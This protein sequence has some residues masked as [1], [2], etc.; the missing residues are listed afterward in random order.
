MAIRGILFDIGDT[1]V[2]ATRLQQEVLRE[3]VYAF[4]AR[5]MVSNPDTLIRVYQRADR[6]PR[7]A[8]TPDLNHLYSDRRIIQR[9]FQFLRRKF[10]PP[11]GTRFLKTYRRLLRSRLQPDPSQ[12]KI[13]K[14]LRAKKIRLGIVSNG[15]TLEQLDQLKRL[16]IEKFFDPILISQQVGIRKPDPRICL[17]AAQQWHLPPHE[18]LVVGD[19]GDWEVL[20]AYRAGMLS[21][22]TKQF[23]DQRHT[24]LP[25]VQPTCVI[26]DLNELLDMI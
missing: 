11:F 24:I 12:I 7:F 3:T 9:A 13:L 4:A 25:D 15:T 5:G 20:C 19:R 8:D 23:V 26:A 21:A 16:G 2:A 1:L 22:L 6:D 17:M 10:D 18:I 14:Q